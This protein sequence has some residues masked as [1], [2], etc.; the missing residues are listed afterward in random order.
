M[1]RYRSIRHARYVAVPMASLTDLVAATAGGLAQVFLGRLSRPKLRKIAC[2]LSHVELMV[3]QVRR[4]RPH[5]GVRRFIPHALGTRGFL[6]QLQAAGLRYAALRWFESLPELPAGEDLDLLVDDADLA[7]VRGLLDDGPGTQAVDLYSAS[8]APGA[9]FRQIA[10][11]PPFLA[12]Q[13]LDRAVVH[14]SRC[15]VP[16]PHDHFLSL[17]YHALYHKGWASGLPS[18]D[19]ARRSRVRPEHDYTAILQEMARRLDIRVSITLDDL[20]DYLDTAG[21]QPPRDTLI[22]LSRHNRWLRALV[23]RSAMRPDDAR[24]GVFLLRREALA[25]GG[26]QRAVEQIQL[27]GFQ[28]VETLSLKPQQVERATRNIRGGTWTAGPWQHSGG[29]PAAAIVVYDAHPIPPTWRQRRR[30]PLVAN[31]RFLTKDQIRDVFNEGLPK[32]EHC[33]VI[34]SSDTDHE[35]ID[36]LRIIAPDKVDDILARVRKFVAPANASALGESPISRAA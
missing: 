23:G 30:F 19:S 35:A 4:P 28:I 16:S 34:H 2:G 32:S 1:L 33:N 25:R 22:K 27:H 3:F 12:E 29:P 17:A 9:D 21:W 18:R 13:I 11:Y 14:R 7:A 15:R 8:G 24:L 6:E 10:Y 36:Y 31:A 26:V 5:R 20:H